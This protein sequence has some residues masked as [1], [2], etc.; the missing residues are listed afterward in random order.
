MLETLMRLWKDDSTPRAH[1]L[2]F[3][4][5]MKP[6][7]SA[8][9]KKWY[10]NIAMQAGNQWLVYGE[11]SNVLKI[12]SAPDWRV[13]ATF[14]KILPLS[15]MQRQK[16]V[17]NNP[18]INVRPA[19]DLSDTDKGAA[20]L[21]RQFLRAKWRDIEFQDELGEF[22]M[23]MVPC[24]VGYFITVWDA[25]DGVEIAPGAGVGIGDGKIIAVPPFEIIP[26]FTYT[27]FS[28]MT[29]FVRA[30]VRTLEYIESRYGKKVKPQKIDGDTMFQMRAQAMMAGSRD[31]LEKI[32]DHHA[33]VLDMYEMPSTQYPQGFHHVCTEDEDLIKQGTMEPYYTKTSNNGK[34]Y[35]LNL[36]AAQ[37]IRLPGML[38][39]TNSVEQATPAQ[40]YLNQGKSTILENIK[41]I[42]RPKIFA[43]IDK[44]PAG[45]LVDDPA[46]VIMEYDA[47]I[48]GEIIPHK[49]P[50]MAQYHLD[51]IRSLP[52][53]IQDMFGI[54]EATTG[55]LPRRATSGKAISFLIEQDE[56]RHFS[57]KQE[58]DRAISG[59]FRKLLNVCANS[60]SEE[61]V[62]DLI[63]D[64]NKIITQKINGSA[65]RVVDVTI[66]RDVSLPKEASARM[67]LALEILGKNPTS[68]QIDIVFSI[69]KADSI[70]SLQALLKGSSTAQEIYAQMENYDM[71]KGL[72]RPVAP[73]ENHQMHKKTHNML[74]A[75]PIP[76]IL[77]AGIMKHNADHD[78]QAGLEAAMKNAAGGEPGTIPGEEPAPEEMQPPIAQ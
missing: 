63:G 73:G 32:L 42:S 52:A 56:E 36:D 11:N 5:A 12:P 31:N 7:H 38:I 47:S 29:R 75:S 45:A 34:E 33:L 68:E 50:E 15:I 25:R 58:I 8:M 69:M 2:G 9:C 23:W 49:P 71:A 39:G 20:D 4:E 48:E 27:R 61:R 17:P 55:V 13:R 76:E 43:P 64:D 57:P 54:H 72:V 22:A 78:A 35:F 24:T 30:T 40:C 18:T 28:D 60:Y 3:Y 44:I 6:I 37:M 74:L 26:D 1:V 65:L 10:Y 41:R 53:E 62:A 67:E 16:L 21:A 59:A 70:E 51:F 66:T 14:N 46:Q 77:K 19:N